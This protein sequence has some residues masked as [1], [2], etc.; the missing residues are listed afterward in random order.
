MEK[1]TISLRTKTIT[2]IPFLFFHLPF[3]FLS[4]S[5]V[6]FFFL[7]WKTVICSNSSLDKDKESDTES[8]DSRRTQIDNISDSDSVSLRKK[9]WIIFHSIALSLNTHWAIIDRSQLKK[10]LGSKVRRTV[11]KAKMMASEV[12]LTRQK[13]E[14]IDIPDELTGGE[15]H[16]KVRISF[17]PP[18][19]SPPPFPTYFFV[20]LSIVLF[21]SDVVPQ[22]ASITAEWS[23]IVN[24]YRSM[25]LALS[26]DDWWG[27]FRCMS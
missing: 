10:F 2:A 22:S 16:V 19:P 23:L 13:E 6:F 21:G 8:I 5:F 18:P 14:M 9:T 25:A 24:W 12:S 27:S 4:F 20:F 11:G 15:Q 3:C 7:Y 1:V 17:S 26:I